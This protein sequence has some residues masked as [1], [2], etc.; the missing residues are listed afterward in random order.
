LLRDRSKKTKQTGNSNNYAAI[1]ILAPVGKDV[2]RTALIRDELR[3][4]AFS[5]TQKSPV[6]DAGL[7][8]NQNTPCSVTDDGDMP[9]QGRHEA[10]W[11]RFGDFPLNPHDKTDFYEKTYKKL[12]L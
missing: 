3:T 9:G 1:F 8:Y 2:D 10:L 5:F 11:E 6:M 12:L 7:Q 4:L